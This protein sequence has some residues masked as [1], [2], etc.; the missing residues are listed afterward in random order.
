MPIESAISVYSAWR[1]L[2]YDAIFY[3]AFFIFPWK[4]WRL[5]KK[6]KRNK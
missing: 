3:V 2:N 1:F 6:K 5:K 4:I